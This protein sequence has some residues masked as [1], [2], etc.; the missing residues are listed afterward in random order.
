MIRR[1]NRFHGRRAVSRVRGFLVHSDNFSLRI[2]RSDQADYRAAVVV[3]KK[4][5]SSAVV[6]NRIRR[7][8]F[9]AIR[10][11]MLFSAQAVDVIVYVKTPAVATVAWNELI[12]ELQVLS[13]RATQ[14][15]ASAKST[16][17]T[18]HTVK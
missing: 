15:Q 4:V 11:E 12:N 6:R 7:R 3:S 13:K 8:I 9:E 1:D 2:G 5:A 17:R 10:T 14:K 18:H 16:P